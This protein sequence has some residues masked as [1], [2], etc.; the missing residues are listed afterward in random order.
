MKNRKPK[1]VPEQKIRTPHDQL[2]IEAAQWDERR[3]IPAGFTDAPEAIPNASQSVAISLRMPNQLLELLKKFA[4]REGVG[5]QVLIK[6]WL[7]DRLRAELVRIKNE[8]AARSIEHA[9]KPQQ[10]PK[11]RA[12][13]FPLKDRPDPNGPHY[14][15]GEP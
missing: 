10:G 2:A 8:R 12:P 15:S 6:R 11:G 9:Q 14:T 7:D 1:S 4:K 13:S 5:Y 3:R